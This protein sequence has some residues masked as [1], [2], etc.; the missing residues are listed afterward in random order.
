[1][2]K[3]VQCGSSSYLASALVSVC[4]LKAPSGLLEL[5]SSKV[6]GAILCQP[7]RAVLAKAL[8]RR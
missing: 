6:S 8:L 3:G 2:M 4:R 1:M 7:S 5:A